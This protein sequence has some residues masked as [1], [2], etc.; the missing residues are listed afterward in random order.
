MS[1]DTPTNED[2]LKAARNGDEDALAALVERHRDRFL[3]EFFGGT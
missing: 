3:R 1:A 2:L